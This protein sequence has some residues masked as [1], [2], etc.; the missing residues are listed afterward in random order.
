[1]YD[2]GEYER[3]YNLQVAD[4]H[5]YFVGGPGVDALWAHNA[6]VNFVMVELGDSAGIAWAQDGWNY[7]Q[8]N[9][10]NPNFSVEVRRRWRIGEKTAACVR[11]SS[12][13]RPRWYA[14]GMTAGRDTH[15]EENL[16][17][18][19]HGRYPGTAGTITVGFSER[20]PCNTVT[21]YCETRV[22]NWL[23]PQDGDCI[24][25]YYLIEHVPNQPGS[26][27]LARYNY[28]LNGGPWPPP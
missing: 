27:L 6:C 10:R 16:I 28:L 18:G 14:S 12:D 1:V 13:D 15:A 8:G 3:V 25:W 22:R 21:H 5:T 17:D 11:V 9:T 24:T 20:H 19:L 2:S 4:Y 23:Q 26:Y 7:R